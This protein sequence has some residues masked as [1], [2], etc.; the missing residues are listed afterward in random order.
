MENGWRMGDLI[1]NPTHSHEECMTEYRRDQFKNKLQ[2]I[3]IGKE[4]NNPRQKNKTSLQNQTINK[5]IK[6]LWLIGLK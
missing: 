6:S 2:S 3:R 1:I 5:G 4:K